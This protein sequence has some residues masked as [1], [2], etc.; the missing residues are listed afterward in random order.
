MKLSFFLISVMCLFV[1][2]CETSTEKGI[3]CGT[4]ECVDACDAVQDATPELEAAEEGGE[5]IVTS[6]MV[7]DPCKAD[8]ECKTNFCLT[9]T[10]LEKMGLV[11]PGLDP[12]WGICSKM[13]CIDDGE[14]GAGGKCFDTQPFTG[15]PIK[16]CLRSC[17]DMFD[18][19]YK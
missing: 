15:S 3:Q 1:F 4:D 18:C 7:G 12:E 6:G 14:C 19:G 9:T 8:A 2:A 11:I 10:F 13:F 5:A 16:A 17:E